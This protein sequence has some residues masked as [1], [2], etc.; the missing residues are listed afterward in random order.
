MEQALLDKVQKAINAPMIGDILFDDEEL[1]ELYAHARRSLYVFGS[2]SEQSYAIALVAFVNIVK[3]WNPEKSQFLDFIYKKI[4][5]D[6]SFNAGIYELLRN[7]VNRIGESKKIYLINQGKKYYATLCSHAF[8]PVSSLNSFFD[9][10][11]EIYYKD[12]NQQ[13]I[14]SDYFFNEVIEALTDRFKSTDDLNDSISIGSSVYSIRVGIRGMAFTAKKEMGWLLDNTINII[15]SLFNERQVVPDTYLK[16]LIKQWWLNKLSSI[17]VKKNNSQIPKDS[18]IVSDFSQI[19]ARYVFK[20]D[21]INIEIPVL[22][23][24]KDT[25]VKPII[26]VFD[27]NGVF[28]NET[29][30][31]WGSGIVSSTTKTDF[32][33][34]LIH[35]LSKIRIVIIHNDRVIFDSRETMYRSFI[36]F[37]DTKEIMSDNIRPGLYYA[38]VKDESDLIHR[39]ANTYKTADFLYKIYAKNGDLIQYKDK[40]ILFLKEDIRTRDVYIAADK[41]DEILFRKNNS[42]YSVIDGDVK[43]GISAKLFLGDIGVR[44]EEAPLKLSQFPNE[45]V[46]GYSRFCITELLNVGEPQKISIFKYSDGTIL[47]SISIIKFNNITYSFDKELYYGEA[48]S[49]SVRFDTE[50]YH[51]SSS[52]SSND[53][54]ALFS[55]EEGEIEVPIP[56]LIW[57]IDEGEWHNKPMNQ[58]LWHE[59]IC[60]STSIFIKHPKNDLVR[61]FV[62]EKEVET[63]TDGNG[64]KLGKSIKNLKRKEPQ[65]QSAR[66][67]IFV[68]GQYY[69]VM[70]V[71]FEKHFA[72]TPLAI[73]SIEKIMTWLPDSFCG[74]LTDSFE[75]IILRY[76]KEVFRCCLPK[77]SLNIS[78][79]RFDINYYTALIKLVPQNN[80]KDPLLLYRTDFYLGTEN[81]VR[82]KHKTLAI[83]SAIATGN[84]FYMVRV[85]NLYIDSIEYLGEQDGFEYYA[86]KLF[87]KEGAEKRYLNTMTDSKNE[88][89]IIN[90]LRIEIKTNLSCYIGYGLDTSDE[91]FEYDDEF[92]IDRRG[93]ITIGTFCDG[94]KTIPID[95]FVFTI[96]EE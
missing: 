69:D 90:P 45:N 12:L 56:W 23:F 20:N 26:R 79:A 88:K 48:L 52:F 39:P 15:D 38:Y 84:S 55:F 57:R 16:K 58:S 17:G 74:D 94:K 85:S 27:E 21:A 91:E 65:L 51:L 60:D 67:R 83:K 33:L 28:L 87:E 61:L 32:S 31:I 19:K 46:A 42:E 24:L 30:P 80:E 5:N 72:A 9:L 53:V 8:A 47:E 92:A 89:H 68:G 78:L 93:K 22:R 1:E 82:F 86:G 77:N 6:S 25:S 34:N 54:T 96:I 14:K 63:E 62:N 4:T 3:E 36:L 81:E 7:A 43:I 73:N 35:D 44:Y 76:G 70:N 29:I 71:V 41:K 10:C 50:K 49:G 40:T 64:F 66:I 95:Y 11:W 37:N 2:L 75:L 13:Y 18:R 59:D